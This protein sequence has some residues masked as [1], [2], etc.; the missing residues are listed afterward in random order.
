MLP[1]SIWGFSHSTKQTDVLLYFRLFYF[2]LKSS[3]DR[4]F[5]MLTALSLEKPTGSWHWSLRSGDC[6]LQVR[7]PQVSFFAETK[8]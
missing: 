2:P 7:F 8:K 6:V 4:N 5:M 3:A 1:S